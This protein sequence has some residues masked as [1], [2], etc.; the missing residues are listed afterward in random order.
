MAKRIDGSALRQIHKLFSLGV[1]RELTDGQILK[2]FATGNG[3]DAERAFANLVERHGPM[4]LRVCRAILRN[5]HDAQDAFQ[6]TFLV[7]VR[8]ARILWVRDSLGPWLYQVA[9]RTAL[10]ARSAA[11][12][13]TRHETRIAAIALLEPATKESPEFHS[14]LHE[15]LSRLPAH[16]RAA[17]VACYLE[18]L[19]CEEAARRLGCP[20]GTVKS[21]LS[22]GRERLKSRLTRRGVGVTDGALAIF[23][24]TEVE[25]A[26]PKALKELTIR[27]AVTVAAGRATTGLISAS[28]ATL[29]EG[30]LRTM[31]LTKI[32]ALAAVLLILGAGTV[33]LAYQATSGPRDDSGPVKKTGL[34]TAKKDAP[35]PAARAVDLKA[36]TKALQDRLEKPIALRIPNDTTLEAAL[37]II[38]EATTGP[39]DAGA[40][41]YVDPAG[42]QEAKAA[43]NKPIFTGVSEDK[44]PLKEHLRSLLRPLGLDFDVQ[45]GLLLISSRDKVVDQKLWR[46]SED[47]RK[48]TERLPLN[49][50]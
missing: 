10:S 26:V 42:L 9:Y 2:R 17:V 32:K 47:L 19:T 6:A 1:E 21:R 37:K 11:A 48:V 5:P 46:L 8:K 29:L 23:F 16:F 25:S 28:V 31:L 14:A 4:V 39:D 50:P 7:L 33:V 44:L 40:P 41:I 13:R 27:A 24:S 3:D 36:K 18:G 15:E 43:M 38:K 49:S 12:R 35:P 45:D 34:T 30:V 22:R 20:V